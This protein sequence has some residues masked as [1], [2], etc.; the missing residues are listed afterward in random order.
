MIQV[1][2]SGIQ[3]FLSQSE[4][5]K[6]APEGEGAFYSLIH[7]DRPGNDYIGWVNYPKAYSKEEVKKIDMITMTCKIYEKWFN[8]LR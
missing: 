8:L 6:L 4:I 7:G 2:I 1:D 5:S 3:N